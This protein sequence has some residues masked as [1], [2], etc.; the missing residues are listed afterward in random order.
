[1]HIRLFFLTLLFAPGCR[2]QTVDADPS[3][4]S[5][6]DVVVASDATL[7]EEEDTQPPPPALFEQSTPL[8]TPELPDGLSHLG[9]DG[10][11][12]CHWPVVEAWKTSAHFGEP[13]TAMQKALQAKMNKLDSVRTTPS[14]LQ[15]M[16]VRPLDLSNFSN[17]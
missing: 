14:S 1:M 16:R 6:T 7:S 10:C 3:G 5:L 4:Q 12:A 8:P 17:L 11:A 15:L 2:S 13:S 9:A